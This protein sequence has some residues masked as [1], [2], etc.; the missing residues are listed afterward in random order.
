[1]IMVSRSGRNPTV[2]IPNPTAAHQPISSYFLALDILRVAEA[3]RR[4]RSTT[5]PP[6]L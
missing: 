3:T 4:S 6:D 2:Y 5:P 1:M